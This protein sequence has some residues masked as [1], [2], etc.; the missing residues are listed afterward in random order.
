MNL[1]R[2]LLELKAKREQQLKAAEAAIENRQAD[3]YKKAMD[4]VSESNTEIERIQKL[5]DE[6]NRFSGGSAS[7]PGMSAHEETPEEQSRSKQLKALI[8]TPQYKSLFCKALCNGIPSAKLT[9]GYENLYKAMTLAGGDP[10]GSDGGFLAPPDFETRVIELARDMVDLS[11][12]VTVIPVNSA[13]GWRNVEESTGR[14]R[15]QKLAEDE[16]A[17]LGNGPKFKQ[18]KFNC[19]TYGDFIAVSGELMEDADGL[20][21]YLAVWFAKRFVVTKNVLILDILDKKEVKA[22]EGETDTEKVKAIKTVLNKGIPTAASKKAIILTNQD[23]YNEMDCWSNELGI[24]YLKPDVSGD[25]ERLKNRPIV[26]GDNDLIESGED[27]TAPI[28]IGDLRAAVA[29]IVRHGIRLAVTNVGG[30][31]WRKHGFEVRAT[32]QMDCQEVDSAAVV[33]RSI[34]VEAE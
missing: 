9:P 31:A 19:E 14:T 21:E 16:T 27:G 17:A 8:S 13:N 6:Q 25:G 4:E 29:L 7:T 12:Y 10:V 11:E 28:Y 22:I 18:I 23:G 1:N 20:M 30:D 34:A 24:P 5:L 2:M 33:K 15:M 3:Q 32:C 26:Y